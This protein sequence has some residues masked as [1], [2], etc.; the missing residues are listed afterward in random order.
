MAKTMNHEQAFRDAVTEIMLE[1]INSQAFH[2]AVVNIILDY[3]QRQQEQNRLRELQRR[4]SMS[5]W[6]NG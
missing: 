3:T 1:T 2:D 4:A 6:Y 5:D